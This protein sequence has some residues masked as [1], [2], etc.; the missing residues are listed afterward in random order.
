[1]VSKDKLKRNRNRNKIGRRRFLTEEVENK[2][3]ERIK[4][5]N[6]EKDTSNER[7]QDD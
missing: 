6:T 3:W 2:E 1:M 4:N 5:R 7:K